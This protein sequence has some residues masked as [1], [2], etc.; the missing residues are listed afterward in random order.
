MKYSI[1]DVAKLP[2][3]QIHDTEEYGDTEECV[4]TEDY[5]K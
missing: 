3:K 5:D 2:I 4:A 1:L